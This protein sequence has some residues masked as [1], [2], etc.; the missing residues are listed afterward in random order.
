MIMSFALSIFL[1]IKGRGAADSHAT[2]SFFYDFYMGIERNPRVGWLDLKYF[3]ELRPGIIGWSC[4]CLVFAMAQHE[5][6]GYIHP[7]I[8]VSGTNGPLYLLFARWLLL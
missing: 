6:Y 4:L 3:F 7:A 5:L 2:G 8:I 1:Y